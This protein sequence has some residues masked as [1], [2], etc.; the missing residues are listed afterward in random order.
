MGLA[1]PYAFQD[2]FVFSFFFLVVLKE[3]ALLHPS[4]CPSVLT[5][6]VAHTTNHNGR[7]SRLFL[8][9]GFYHH[10]AVARGAYVGVTRSFKTSRFALH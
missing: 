3:W 9:P 7:Q 10:R 4:I 8:H 2:F 5:R 1:F 6:F